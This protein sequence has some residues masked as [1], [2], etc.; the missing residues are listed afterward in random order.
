[1]G[2]FSFYKFLGVTGRFGGEPEVPACPRASRKIGPE[3][4]AAS[5]GLLWEFQELPFPHRRF[6]RSGRFEF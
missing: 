1:M 2:D 4:P 3:V 5:S 6:G